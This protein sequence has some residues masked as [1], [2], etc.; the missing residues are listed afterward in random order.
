MSRNSRRCSLFPRGH[1]RGLRL[2]VVK[3]NVGQIFILKSH[4]DVAGTVPETCISIQRISREQE[5]HF[6]VHGSAPLRENLSRYKNYSDEKN[7][8]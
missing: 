7:N 8:S 2:N 4:R 3:R 5:L 6:D 1:N